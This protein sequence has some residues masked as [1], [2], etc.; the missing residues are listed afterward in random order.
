MIGALLLATIAFVPLDDRPV[1]RQLPQLLGR[2]AGVPVFE[3]LGMY[4]STSCS[5]IAAC[6]SGRTALRAL[7]PIRSRLVPS[8]SVR[9]CAASA[10][11]SRASQ[12]NPASAPMT[13]SATPDFVLVMTGNAQA[14]ASSAAL[15]S[16]S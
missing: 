11:E 2:I 1:T 10:A 15:G 16:G 5:V 8:S 12:T 4:S 7:L 9:M 3:T 6:D 13:S 14:I